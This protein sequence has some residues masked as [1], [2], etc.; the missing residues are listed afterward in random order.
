VVK[1]FI[2]LKLIINILKIERK[3]KKMEVATQ[4]VIS[5][6]FAIIM[7]IFLALTY[8]MKDRKIILVLGILSLI[9]ST[10]SYILLNAYTG[11]AMNMVALIR[12]IIFILDE[13][14]NG[15]KEKNNKKDIIILAILYMIITLFTV[16]TYK[17]FFSLFSVFATMLYTYAVWQKKANVYKILGIPIGILWIVYN[18]YVISLFGVIL[19]TVLLICSST[20]YMLEI[21]RLKRSGNT[22]EERI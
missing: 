17:G 3:E 19:E 5:Q 18:V 9:A 21:K 14:K 10:I 2:L 16:F 20:G 11:I 22:V 7:Y 8:Y 6:V 1:C 4:Y 12:N 13:K 15:K